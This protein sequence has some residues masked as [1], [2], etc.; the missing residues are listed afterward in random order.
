MRKCFSAVV[1]GC[2]LLLA[3]CDHFAAYTLT[4]QEINHSLS[5]HAS[6]EKDIGING[7]A[8]AH[9]ILDTLHAEVG[10]AIA[11]QVVLSGHAKIHFASLFG[12]Q[13]A[14]LQI[15]MSA[16][17]VFNREQGA[18]YLHDITIIDIQAEPQK[19]EGIVESLR[20]ILATSLR[21]YFNKQPAWVL[22][23]DRSKA[24]SLAK[25]FAT[26][27]EVKPGQLVIP[28]AP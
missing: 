18:V 12:Q 7:L 23:D 14:D 24:E 28:L 15:K 21:D 3:G 13:D 17:P 16:V 11:N 25:K 6:Y 20:P 27:I 8:N 26:G 9:I 2:S 10:R 22:S 5:K 1:I 4:E 19:V